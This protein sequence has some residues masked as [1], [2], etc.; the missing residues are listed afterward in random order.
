L[1][2]PPSTLLHQ[3][4]LA[5]TLDHLGRWPRPSSVSPLPGCAPTRLPQSPSRPS[6]PPG[7]RLA[8]YLF[9]GCRLDQCCYRRR[10][11]LHPSVTHPRRT[12]LSRG[13][14]YGP[15]APC[16]LGLVKV[17]YGRGPLAPPISF[18]FFFSFLLGVPTGAMACVPSLCAFC[19]GALRPPLVLPPPPAVPCL[20]FPPCSAAPPAPPGDFARDV[21]RGAAAPRGGG[22][23]SGR[24][25]FPFAQSDPRGGLQEQGPPWQG[26]QRCDARHVTPSTKTCPH[27]RVFLSL[28]PLEKKKTEVSVSWV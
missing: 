24:L 19:V 1:R 25:S 22:A 20:L 16:P 26:T 14:R 9:E 2:L 8:A 6:P 4:A 27:P 28:D 5:A 3:R 18:F 10:R 17:R 11:P 7:R 13:R 21:P 23:P 15:A 12:V